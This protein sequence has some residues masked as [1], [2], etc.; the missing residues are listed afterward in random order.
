M[1]AARSLL[2]DDRLWPNSAVAVVASG[3]R[4]RRI[5]CRLRQRTF[6]YLTVPGRGERRTRTE[7]GNEQAVGRRNRSGATDAVGGLPPGPTH[8]NQGSR[9]VVPRRERPPV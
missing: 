3:G 2:K 9:S 5:S 8:L 7:F 6:W 1:S 4:Y